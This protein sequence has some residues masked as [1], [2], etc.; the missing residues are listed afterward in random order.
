VDKV[1]IAQKSLGR[2]INKLSPGS[3]TSVTK[4]D[5]RVLDAIG[6]R[7]IG[8]YGSRESIVSLLVEA[9]VVDDTQ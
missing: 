6:V 4:V 1:I 8:V 9:G 5:F 3:Y 7:P 2:F